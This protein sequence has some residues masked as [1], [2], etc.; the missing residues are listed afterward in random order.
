MSL[1]ECRYRGGRRHYL[2]YDPFSPVVIEL[3]PR[4][5]GLLCLHPKMTSVFQGDYN[6][7]ITISRCRYCLVNEWCPE[8]WR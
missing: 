1:P 4:N 2:Q 6:L 5:K 8:G 3:Q 7:Y